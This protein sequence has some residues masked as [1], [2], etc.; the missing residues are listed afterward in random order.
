MGIICFVLLF[1]LSKKKC[2]GKIKCNFVGRG[3]IV[4]SFLIVLIHGYQ[5][6]YF[7]K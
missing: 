6:I 1:F 3:W 4:G 7:K 5:K 2:E